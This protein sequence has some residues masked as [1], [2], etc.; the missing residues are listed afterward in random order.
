[1]SEPLPDLRDATPDDFPGLVRLFARHYA[2][3]KPEAYFKWQYFS[4]AM[5]TALVVAVAGGEVVGSFGGMRRPLTGGFHAAQ[6]MD[7]LLDRRFR[8]RGVFEAMAARAAAA[9]PEVDVRIVLANRAGMEAVVR[10]LGWSVIA[11]VPLY[12]AE[13]AAG[14]P[15]G[16]EASDPEAGP[17]PCRILYDEAIERWRFAEHPF[18][19]YH[20]LEAGG[21]RGY[22][23]VFA[24]PADSGRRFGDILQ[25]APGE[26]GSTEAWLRDALEWFRGQGVGTCGLWALPGAPA[27]R[28]ALRAGFVPRPQERWLCGMA[29]DPETPTGRR[30]LCWDVCA[31]DAEFY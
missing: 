9:L 20:R 29:P 26:P 8:G 25:I 18:H 21:T 23:K 31:A 15:A 4:S 6:A 28:S 19:R 3:F 16:E 7:M 5:P 24:D 12:A 2:Q 10:R 13:V 11:E 22:L 30:D 14:P 17:E 27:A 1:M